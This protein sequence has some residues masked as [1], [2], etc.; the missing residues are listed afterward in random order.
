MI[1]KHTFV[2]EAKETRAKFAAA[3]SMYSVTDNKRLRTEADTLLI[4]FDQ[5]IER[6]ET[7]TQYK[8]HRP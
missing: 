6:I 7:T 1:D 5:A 4:M 2:C 3:V 8:P